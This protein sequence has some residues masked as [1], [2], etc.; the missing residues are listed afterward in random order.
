MGIYANEGPE[1]S[2]IEGVHSRWSLR[3]E[4]GLASVAEADEYGARTP[5]RG[6]G[7]L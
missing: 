4:C 3:K 2:V 1:R 6:V 7:A 5:R